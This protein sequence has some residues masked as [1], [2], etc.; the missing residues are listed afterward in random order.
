MKKLIL[1]SSLIIAIILVAQPVRPPRGGG[2]GGGGSSGSSTNADNLTVT[3]FIRGPRVILGLSGTN[4]TGLDLNL[5]TEFILRLT[6]NIF[7]GTPS[8][9]PNTN[10]WQT[11]AI[12]L[13]NDGVG[14]YTVGWTNGS[15]GWQGGA[16]PVKTT[17]ANAYDI[18]TFTVSAL[19]NNTLMGVQTFDVHR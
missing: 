1:F 12:H 10:T 18:Y 14:G 7:F 15:F 9:I 5:G 2:S 4:V 13:I 17:N 11:I 8:N 6:T 16:V 3:N 19:T